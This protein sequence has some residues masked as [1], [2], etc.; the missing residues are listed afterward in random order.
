MGLE[1]LYDFF[2]GGGEG[3]V[4]DEG[5]GLAL[6]GVVAAEELE[7]AGYQGFDAGVLID[8]GAVAGVG[9]ALGVLLWVEDVAGGGLFGVG[10]VDLEPFAD[11][12]LGP[13]GVVEVDGVGCAVHGGDDPDLVCRDAVAELEAV[14]G[15][16]D[17][18]EEVAVVDGV[19]VVDLLALALE[20]D[21]LVEVGEVPVVVLVDEVGVGGG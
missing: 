13:H 8:G 5:G 19:A 14:E 7:A 11:L 16:L 21:E 17:G 6:G 10:V 3:V 2:D 18:A 20:L 9:S 12:V 4:L 1:I 15:V